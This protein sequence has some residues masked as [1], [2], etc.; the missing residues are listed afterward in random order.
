[1]SIN[2][3]KNY[4][5]LVIPTILAG[6]LIAQFSLSVFLIFALI[7]GILFVFK[8]PDKTLLVLIFYLPFQIA[9]NISSGI[10]LASGRVLIMVI[11]GIWFFK[12][13][14]E[15]KI[16]IA[17]NIQTFLL[18]LFLS[19]AL[20]SF[21][22]AWDLERA[23]R[24]FLVFLS[25][26][27]LYF[28]ITS[29]SVPNSFSLRREKINSPLM[30]EGI[31][32]V[33]QISNF[34]SPISNFISKILN[35]IFLSAII[36]S[37]IGIVQFTLQFIIGIDPIMNFWK[38]NI[39]SIFY[40]R[41]F[42]AEVI[43]NPSW[44]VNIGGVTILRSFSLFPDPHMFS[45]Y[46]GLI[47][48]IPLAFLLIPLSGGGW[49]WVKSARGKPTPNPSQERNNLAQLYPKRGLILFLIFLTFLIL[50]IAELLTF[51]R[52]GY[53]GMIFGIGTVI[54]LGWRFISFNKKIFLGIISATLILFILFAA[55][56]I[57]N[58]F[59]SIS[60]LSEGSNIGRLAI[61]QEANEVWQN[62]FFW[63]VG[64]GNYSVEINPAAD[65]RTPI[66]AH[67]VYLDIA[68]EMGVF[69][70]L[71]WL[72]L[73]LITSVQLFQRSRKA[74]DN[75][76]RALSLG[77]CGSLIWFFVHCFFDT[78]IYSPKILAMLMV[79]FALSATVIKS[80]R[81]LSKN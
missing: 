75:F 11:F 39:A 45:F 74:D 56:P 70:L 54:I 67:N 44:L 37:I 2:A 34:Q 66:Y 60:D 21:L 73:F 78:P 48:P 31:G 5:L 30:K 18:F 50:L 19:L 25:I 61:W 52:G 46:L 49:G 42:G 17:K 23:A 7:I 41:S 55:Q 57:L 3:F 47:I 69:S 16:I 68:T 10:D 13:L 36:L 64:L 71:T 14:A 35:A 40:G 79:I 27:P 8:Y 15:R 12:S 22:Q 24:K 63:G 20:F 29:L 65:Y 28:L 26:F 1:M 4:L 58:R 72:G 6:F 53:L 62:H 32:R 80:P 81:F 77:L 51:S 38:D 43:S 9:F 59:I 33:Q 76:T